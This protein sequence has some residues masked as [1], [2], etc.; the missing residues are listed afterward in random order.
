[1]VGGGRDG[2]DF[3]AGEEGGG[4]DGDTIMTDEAT[5][6]GRQKPARRLAVGQGSRLRA[7]STLAG[8]PG[9]AGGPLLL[10]R[11]PGPIPAT[12]DHG[13]GPS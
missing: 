8:L 3:V 4:S 7:S 9:P 12:S 1:M 11:L 13:P 10:S 5:K 6:S 2:L